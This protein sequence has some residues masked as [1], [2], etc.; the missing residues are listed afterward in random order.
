MLTSTRVCSTSL[1]VP[2][3]PHRRVPSDIGSP[4]GSQREGSV[5]AST[6]LCNPS[7]SPEVASAC[8][9][10]GQALGFQ[11]LGPAPEASAACVH[12]GR[13]GFP[14]AAVATPPRQPP[15]PARPRHSHLLSPPSSCHPS[16]SRDRDDDAWEPGAGAGLRAEDEGATGGAAGVVFRQGWDPGQVLVSAVAL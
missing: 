4:A 1:L 12:S 13:A 11:S 3:T 8:T 10:S 6:R 2:Y 14:E 15:P 9:H 16:R 5:L 7:L